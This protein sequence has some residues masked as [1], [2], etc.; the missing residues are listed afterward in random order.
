[1]EHDA[2]PIDAKA[3]KAAFARTPSCATLEELGR[4]CDADHAGGVDARVALHVAGCLRCRTELA[5][6]KEF[7]AGTPRPEEEPWMAERAARDLPAVLGAAAAPAARAPTSAYARRGALRRVGVGLAV[8]CAALLVALNVRD[9]WPPPLATDVGSGSGSALFRSREM[10][11]LG[12][13]G[14]LGDPP[15]EL[16]WEPVAGAATYAVRVMEVDRDELWSGQSREPSAVLPNAV[17]A[18]IVPGKPLL[19]QVVARDAAGQVIA[20]SELERFR[21]ALRTQQTP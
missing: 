21:V 8:A 19:W 14:D 13:S 3:I 1:V 4:L 11:L 18:R 9:A 7:E 10:T 6:V 15:R 17:R 2:F 20:T 16:R 12:P 5:L